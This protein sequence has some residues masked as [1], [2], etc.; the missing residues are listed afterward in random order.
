VKKLL[1]KIIKPFNPGSSRAQEKQTL[2]VKVNQGAE[3][4][5]TEYKKTFQILAD[6]DKQ[7]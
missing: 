6:S 5:I 3:K 1:E 7:L 4:A 2:E